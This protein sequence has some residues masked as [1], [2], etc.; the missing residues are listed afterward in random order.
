MIKNLFWHIAF[1]A[2]WSYTCWWW[3]RFSVCLDPTPIL[4]ERSLFDSFKMSP[5]KTLI[6]HNVVAGYLWAPFISIVFD[7]LFEG[8]YLINSQFFSRICNCCSQMPKKSVAI[9]GPSSGVIQ[10]LFTFSC[11]LNFIQSIF[12]SVAWV[13][14]MGRLGRF[15][16]PLGKRK[17][18]NVL[19]WCFFT[20]N[21]NYY[22]LLFIL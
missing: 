20:N 4:V 2:V 12:R 16:R 5:P 15:G 17:K 3:K 19:L 14:S 13:P 9:V 1:L 7:T 18:E 6:I 8:A 21:T 10:H 11:D 22:Y